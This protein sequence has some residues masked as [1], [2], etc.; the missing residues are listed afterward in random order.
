MK[1]ASKD[2]DSRRQFPKQARPGSP[3]CYDRERG[4][5]RLGKFRIPGR[6]AKR[7]QRRVMKLEGRP[8]LHSESVGV[9]KVHGLERGGR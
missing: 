1:S 7:S 3:C 5:R 8:W 4:G 2:Q 9:R 6:R